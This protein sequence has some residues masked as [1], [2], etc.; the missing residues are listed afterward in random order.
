MKKIKF[1]NL[2]GNLGNDLIKRIYAKAYRL[3]ATEVVVKSGKYG[4]Y[5]VVDM[6]EGNDCIVEN[7]TI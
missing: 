6:F 7:Y 3:E 2:A 4:R 1:T 5:A